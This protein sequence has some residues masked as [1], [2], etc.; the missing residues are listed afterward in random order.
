MSVKVFPLAVTKVDWASFVSFAQSTFGYN[1]A[2]GINESNEYNL[3]IRSLKNLKRSKNPHHHLY[4]TVGV[5][6]NRKLFHDLLDLENIKIWS[7]VQD[8]KYILIL[9]ADFSSWLAGIERFCRN[10]ADFNTRLLFNKIFLW[11]ERGCPDAI[12]GWQKEPCVDG[13]FLTK[14]G[15]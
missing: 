6:C 2:S 10:E 9:S 1:P 14:R 7:E 8:E 11:L 3:F 13:T 15:R 12:L 4:L 5:E